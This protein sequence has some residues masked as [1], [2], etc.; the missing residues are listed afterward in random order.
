MLDAIDLILTAVAAAGFVTLL[1]VAVRRHVRDGQPGAT[2]LAQL[3][4]VYSLAAV[5]HGVEQLPGLPAAVG[6]P[7]LLLTATAFAVIPLL[8]TRFADV[9]DPVARGIWRL[10]LWATPVLVA[11]ALLYV[12]E[13]LSGLMA[14]AWLAVFLA[15]WVAGHGTAAIRLW[16]GGRGATA[17]V[18]R[19]RSQLMAAA[20]AGLGA[21]L[22]VA[23][24]AGALDQQAESLTGI[25]LFAVV[26]VGL[27][28]L[29]FVPPAALRWHWARRDRDQLALAERRMFE[30]DEPERLAGELLPHVTR[31]A[32]GTAAWLF[33]GDEVVVAVPDGASPVWTPDAGESA[34][35][36][37]VR[38]ATDGS[39]HVLVAPT[40]RG[41]FVVRVD[42]YA[43]LFGARDL[44]AVGVLAVHLD[45]ALDRARLKARELLTIREV[46][47][48]RRVAEVER[49]RDDVLSTVSHEMRTP[50]TSVCGV[51]SLLVQRWDELDDTR[52]RTLV[53]RLETN[54][55]DLRRVVEDLL[56]LTAQRMGRFAAPSPEPVPLVPLVTRLVTGLHGQL[57]GRDVAVQI[58]GEPVVELDVA[59]VEQ[60]LRHLLVNAAKFSPAHEPVEL[61]VDTIGR[62][63]RLTVVDRGPGMEPGDLSLAFEAF[64]RGGD[65]LRRETRGLGVGLALVAALAE[66][67]GATIEPVSVPDRGTEVTLVLPDALRSPPGHEAARSRAMS[68]EGP[69]G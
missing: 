29:G 28:L 18:A 44:D 55:D 20:V 62:D 13:V 35:Q 52:R 49:I 11:G 59:S 31:L 16:R 12:L 33:A 38:A 42:P 30:I 40:V 47:A 61:R 53:A 68:A 15:L 57:D 36:V 45:V 19:R 63:V 37:Q 17:A 41:C 1:A 5:L 60:I 65:V 64:H 25:L 10:A 66:T 24:L 6:L 21:L 48:A 56:Q 4:G 58:P 2:E 9:F 50:L 23:G 34:G 43:L 3:L 54:A 7:V 22:P 32:G 26:T 27:L 69:V 39:G 67:L 14:S 51:S 8:V 46:D